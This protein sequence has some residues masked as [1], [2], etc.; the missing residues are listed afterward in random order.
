MSVDSKSSGTPVTI[1]QS[2]SDLRL[3]HARLLEEHGATAALL[4]Q[5]EAQ[6][7][8]YERREV[9]LQD[10][11]LSLQQEL[12]TAITQV[13]RREARAALA[14]R[15]T[16]YLQALLASFNSEANLDMDNAERIDRTK[17]MKIEQ[18][19]RLLS[20]Y[21]MVNEQLQ[22]E[23]DG[24]GGPWTTGNGRSRQEPSEE[25]DRVHTGYVNCLVPCFASHL[26]L[27]EANSEMNL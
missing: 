17:V 19:E 1:T 9:E 13:T 24:L 16:G 25:L 15:E 4:R 18:L 3:T 8:K 12:R 27:D 7:E 21:K 14:E 10:T 22:K 2:L 23:V 11:I 5:S 6:L 20:E 26:D